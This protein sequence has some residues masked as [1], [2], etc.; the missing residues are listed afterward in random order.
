MMDMDKAVNEAKASMMPFESWERLKGESPMAFAAF[1][2][3]R[4]CGSE[5]SIRMAVDETEKNEA[6]RAKR[7]RVWRNWAAQ[8]SWRERAADYDR[9][10]VSHPKQNSK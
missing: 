1:C 5:R 6:V 7:Y 2:A 3:F 8:Y 4:D 9:Y 10:L